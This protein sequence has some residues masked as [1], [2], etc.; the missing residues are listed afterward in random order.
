MKLIKKYKILNNRE[1]KDNS[2]ILQTIMTAK[3]WTPQLKKVS[4]ILMDSPYICITSFIEAT[5]FK[6]IRPKVYVMNSKSKE[7]KVLGKV[8]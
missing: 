5:I 6:S 7:R 1:V 8:T 4:R 2:M 3:H